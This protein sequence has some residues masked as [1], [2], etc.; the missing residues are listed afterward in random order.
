MKIGVD[1]DE[2]LAGLLSPVVAFHND[3]YG[4]SLSREKFL[5]FKFWE[6]WGGTEEETSK[7]LHEFYK[8]HYFRNMLPVS[9][10][11]KGV[12]ILAKGNE[13]FVLTSR[14]KVLYNET[15]EWIEKH[16]TGKV[17]GGYFTNEFE[18]KV[19]DVKTKSEICAELGIGLM[20]EDFLGYAVECAS[21][22]IKVLLLDCP[23]NQSDNLPAGVTRVHSWQE[24][25]EKLK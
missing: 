24:I 12:S 4:T 23:W 14:P 10:S 7:K 20:I 19:G 13:L 8:T 21:N 6:V 9:D 17:S 25:V 22:G 3:K 18:K 16:F 15:L 5:S 1:L 11:R 2:V